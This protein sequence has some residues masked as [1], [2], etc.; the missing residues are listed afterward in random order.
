M[1]TETW[2]LSEEAQTATSIKCRYADQVYSLG[3][4][5]P[6]FAG[7]QTLITTAIPYLQTSQFTVFYK[8]PE[9][10]MVAVTT[11]ESLLEAY[12][13]CPGIMKLSISKLVAY[14]EPVQ[15]L[16]L[17]CLL[18]YN[19]LYRRLSGVFTL[20]LSKKAVG[21]GVAVT[22]GLAVTTAPAVHQMEAATHATALF[23]TP[24]FEC[25]LDPSRKYVRSGAITVVSF[26]FALPREVFPLDFRRDYPRRGAMGLTLH[27]PTE[28]TKSCL[29]WVEVK[30]TTED[31][32]QYDCKE[33]CGPSGSPVFSDS[34]ELIGLQTTECVL[35]NAAIPG[36]ALLKVIDT[37]APDVIDVTAD[38]GGHSL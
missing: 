24:G 31:A 25:P 1:N 15:T 19:L 10:D 14:T 29:K 4:P 34:L 20:C 22:G 27:K 5:P 21:M 32:F 33:A 26:K 13:L 30:D 6:S 11:T 38:N 9:G 8:D 28:T 36:V 23:S 37:V 16:A 3:A 17:D 18:D 2:F 7:L 12:K 35:S